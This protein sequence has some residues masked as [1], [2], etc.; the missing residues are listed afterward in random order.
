MVDSGRETI[1][2]RVRRLRIAQRKS[3]GDLAG[4]GVSSA[5]VSRIEVGARVPSAK[6]IRALAR[7]L[8]VRPCYL[9]TGS[10]LS[11]AEELEL[12][13][14]AAAVQL[15]LNE[16]DGDAS[17]DVQAALSEAEAL[18]EPELVV[19]ARVALGLAA[20]AVEDYESAI[21]FLRMVVESGIISPATDPNVYEALAASYSALSRD[22]V[23]LDA[24]PATLEVA[25]EQRSR[26]GSEVHEQV[27]RL[28]AWASAAAAEGRARSA[29]RARRAAVVLLNAALQREKVVR[30]RKG[31][32]G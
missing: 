20:V 18:A 14:L 16:R 15:R 2:D 32:S 1:G 3:Q 17:A 10:E 25:A 31:V 19:E 13:L 9:E 11:D 6:A 23:L 29:L 27:S 21:E 4:P 28:E 8:G 22:G 26:P 30:R 12:R 24:R 7:R 5:Y